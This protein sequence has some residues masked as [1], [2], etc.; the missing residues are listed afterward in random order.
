MAAEAVASQPGERRVYPIMLPFSAPGFTHGHFAH[1]SL[2]MIDWISAALVAW[3][4]LVSLLLVR[5]RGALGRLW[6]EPALAYPVVIVESDDWG[7]GPESD[8]HTLRSIAELLADI[9][10]AEGNPAVMTL[11]VVLGKPDGAAIL[12][13]DCRRYHRSTLE[14]PQYAPIVH[15]IQQ[16]CAAGVFALQRHGLEHCWPASLL[17]RAREDA[18]LRA[19]LADPAARSEALPSPLQS[20]W[21]DA[22][23]LPSRPIPE[24]EIGAAVDEEAALFCRLFGEAPPVAV[25]N[26]FVWTGAVERAWAASGVRCVVTCGRQYEGRAADGGLMPA[27]RQIL[28][29]E[30]GSGGVRY[31]VRDAYFEPIRGHRAE[32]VWQAVAERSPLGRPTLLETHRESFIAAPDVAQQSLAELAR[33]LE[34]VVQRHPDVRCLSTAALTNALGAPDSAM[35]LQG[36]AKRFGVFL[37]RVLAT[38]TLSRSLKLSGLRFLLPVLVRMLR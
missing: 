23:V 17:D 6:R 12:S 24:A 26:T 18:A 5:K 19:W 9:R 10:D 28:N 33:A 8:A 37:R 3:A 11:G 34:G 16:G 30:C 25:P 15:A 22:A 13:D 38:P 31:V 4:S 36:G 7:P 35:L 2:L 32:Q 27:T 1:A 20:R 14:D 21:V 29:G